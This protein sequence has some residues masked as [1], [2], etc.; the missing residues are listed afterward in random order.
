MATTT[1]PP[2]RPGTKLLEA[3]DKRQMSQ[4]ELCQRM[5]RSRKLI[6]EIIKG[7]ASIASDTAFHLELVLGKPAAYWSDLERDYRDHQV[8]EQHA[9]KLEQQLEWL[10]ALPVQ[11]MI[12][13]KWLKGW[14]KGKPPRLEQAQALLRWFGVASPEQ[15][16]E[17]YGEPRG[18]NVSPRGFESDPGALAAWLRAGELQAVGLDTAPYERKA[19]M[20][21]LREIRGLTRKKPATF[22]DKMIRLS[23]RAGVV[24]AWAREMPGLQVAGVSRWLSPK[25]ALIQLSMLHAT[26]AAMWFTFFH[27]AGHIVL[28]GRKQVFVE[29]RVEGRPARDDVLEE[30]EAD[31]F[32]ANLLIPNAAMDDFRERIMRQR[33]TDRLVQTFAREQGIAPGIVVARMERLGWDVPRSLLRLKTPLG[34]A[35]PGTHANV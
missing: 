6:N 21:A 22:Q 25:K 7:K 26:N 34:W 1:A 9:A 18:L 2:P 13:A 14:I 19:F 3:L 30:V 35:K 31:H 15:W 17:V 29:G 5:G 24:L 27:E 28:H 11:E 23:R 12:D 33:L 32:A 8:R 20:A 10:D 4:A 16:R